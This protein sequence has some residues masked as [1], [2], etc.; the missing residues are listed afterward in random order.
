MKEFNRLV[1][2]GG[3]GHCKSVL[4]AVIRLNQF[5]Q[6]VITDDDLAVGT[7]I[8]GCKVVGND[9]LLPD[10]WAQ[11]YR[12]AF[13]AVGSIKN[14]DI[15]RRIYQRAV[16]I[17]FEFPVI[18]DSSAIVARSAQLGAGVFVGKNSVINSDATIGDMSIINT[19]AIVEHGCHIGRFAHIAVGAT[20]CGD[21]SIGNDAFVGANATIVQ[22]VNVGMKGIVGAGALVLGDVGA[23]STV[24][25]VWG[26]K[27]KS[28]YS[29]LSVCS[30]ILHARLYAV[31]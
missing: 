10:L 29:F 11:G 16:K 23:G 7:D 28:R 19:G 20:V 9:N 21:V 17:G 31:S 25:G 22:G 2:L 13:I 4:D 24:V 12:K 3:G 15:R 1:L 30:H 14:T 5:S 26:G 6:I 18:I 8:M 27:I